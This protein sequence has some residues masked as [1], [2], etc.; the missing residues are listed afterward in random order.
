MR[1]RSRVVD[2][3]SI[4][5]K[6]ALVLALTEFFD[7]L[8][9]SAFEEVLERGLAITQSE[10]LGLM[11]SFADFAPALYGAGVMDSFGGAWVFA[12]DEVDDLGRVG[13]RSVEGET[14]AVDED[15]DGILG[16]GGGGS[17]GFSFWPCTRLAGTTPPRSFAFRM[18][19]ARS[20]LLDVP[21][22]R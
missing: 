13:G 4:L 3:P 22:E 1:E 2:C 17:D 6:N 21:G 7:T 18:R 16:N 11:G 12:A 10:P 19:V 15:E 14:A 9:E 5:P 20:G 8:S